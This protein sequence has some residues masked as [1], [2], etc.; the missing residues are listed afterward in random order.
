MVACSSFSPRACIVAPIHVVRVS[1]AVSGTSMKCEA[2]LSSSFFL[3]WLSE[4]AVWYSGNSRTRRPSFSAASTSA[5]TAL[6]VDVVAALDM[7]SSTSSLRVN[8]P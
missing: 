2:C 3:A 6:M 8:S 4:R 5:M 1:L 7:D